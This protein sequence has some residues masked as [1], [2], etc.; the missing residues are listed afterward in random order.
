MSNKPKNCPECEGEGFIYT[1]IDEKICPK[2]QGT[3]K[4]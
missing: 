1:I 4:L 3:G 2:C